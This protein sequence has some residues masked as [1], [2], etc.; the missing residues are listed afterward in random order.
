[1]DMLN[2][3]HFQNKQNNASGSI[4]YRDWIKPCE[5]RVEQLDIAKFIEDYQILK[6]IIT[7]YITRY[8]ISTSWGEMYYKFYYMC[9][10]NLL[11][12]LY[13]YCS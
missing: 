10:I 2:V 11:E 8:M 1:M 4:S 13:Y 9:K 6:G 7:E 5:C 3:L 12:K